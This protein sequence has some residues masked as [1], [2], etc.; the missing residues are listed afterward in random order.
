[1]RRFRGTA[2]DS[3]GGFGG[4]L[5]LA[6]FLFMPIWAVGCAWNWIKGRFHRA[7]R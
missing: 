4:G 1:M 5:V 2:D 7:P 6:W 3:S